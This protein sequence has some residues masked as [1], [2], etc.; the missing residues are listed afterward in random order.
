MSHILDSAYKMG[1]KAAIRG[2][3]SDRNPFP[4]SITAHEDWYIGWR[5]LVDN[6][7]SYLA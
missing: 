6:L 1:I 4:I 7:D 2:E 3:T 5:Y